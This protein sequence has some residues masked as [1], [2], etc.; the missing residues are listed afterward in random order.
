MSKF[1][2][3]EF[4][5]ADREMVAAGT[6]YSWRSYTD[7]AGVFGNPGAEVIYND[8]VKD[9]RG[10]VVGKAFS[11]GQSHYKL[12]ARENQKDYDGLELHKYFL[13]APFCQGSPNGT[14]TSADG[15]Y[16]DVSGMKRD[17]ILEKLLTGELVQHNVKI[18]LLETELDAQYAADATLKRAEAQVSVG[19]LDDQTLTEIAAMIGVF[20]PANMT[21]KHKVI[22]FAGKRPIDYFKYLNSGDRGVRALIRRGIADGILQQKGTIIYWKETIVGEDE[23]RAVAHLLQD[24]AMFKTLNDACPLKVEKKTAPKKNAAK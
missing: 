17:E 15:G 10:R 5:A 14:Y 9:H 7:R 11:I 23:D 18:K 21:M 13:N 16:V 24:S 2:T 19:G 4:V 22:E 3:Y 20:G 1:T 6:S 8:G 12:V